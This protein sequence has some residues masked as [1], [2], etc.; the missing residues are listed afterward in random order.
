[1]KYQCKVLTPKFKKIVD[2]FLEEYLKEYTKIEKIFK[3]IDTI[4][5]LNKLWKGEYPQYK[6]DFPEV[7]TPEYTTEI[8]ERVDG[9]YQS[10]PRILWKG[11]IT[12]IDDI[13]EIIS[14]KRI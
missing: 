11:E 6:E 4:S 14:F 8:F 7:Y 12:K 2:N 13:D 9:G 1:M 10:Q 3:K 5:F